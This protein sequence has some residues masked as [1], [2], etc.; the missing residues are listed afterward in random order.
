MKA[1]RLSALLFVT[2][3]LA[4]CGETPKYQAEAPA[5]V[6]TTPT[7]PAASSLDNL[8]KNVVVDAVPFQPEAAKVD[9]NALV[10][11]GVPGFVMFGPYVPFVPGS[12]HVIVKGSIPKLQTGAEVHFDVVSNT[13]KTVHGVQVVTTAIPTSGNIAEFDVTIPEGVTDLE[14]RARVTEGADVRIESYQIVKAN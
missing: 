6:A 13:A 5:Q 2:L 9:G 14:L 8:A 7:A 11:T 3:G 1:S 10:S 12:Y 4:A